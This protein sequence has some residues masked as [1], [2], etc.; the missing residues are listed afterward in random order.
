MKE[1]QIGSYAPGEDFL[2][3]IDSD[4]CAFDTMEI[5]HKECFCPAT[6][7]AWG[8]Q[9]VSKYAREIWEYTNLYSK[10]RGRSRFHELVM[11]FD[12]LEKRPE[13]KAC[14]FTPPNVDSLRRWVAE[15]PVLNNEALEMLT[16]DP[17]LR[18][19]LSWSLDS[20]R[21]NREMVSGIPPFPYVRECLKQMDHRCD[22]FIVSATS[23]EALI[24]EWEE[25]DLMQYVSL[26]WGQEDGS[27][28]EC[29]AKYERYYEKGRVLMIGDAPGDMEAAHGNGV[30]FYPICPGQEIESWRELHHT[31]LDMFL[32]GTYEEEQETQR[33]QAFMRCLPDT[34]PWER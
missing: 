5:K 12:W 1:E 6:I 17:V 9:P 4:G 19:T 2:I 23:R 26:V 25:H 33:I 13:I 32:N 3:C 27:K 15:A 30:L 11:L 7:L 20:N 24:R 31:Y 29:L 10:D 22:I 18:R 28:K 8:L 34:P 16:D 14:G 21:R